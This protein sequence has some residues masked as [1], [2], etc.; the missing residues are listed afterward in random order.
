MK[1]K[2]L[3][4]ALA[5]A[6][7]IAL[8]ASCESSEERAEAHYEKAIE[9]IAAGDVDRALVELR[10]VFRLDGYHRE[11]RRAFAEAEL[12]RGQARSAYSQYL[13]L[14]EQYPDDFDAQLALA[15]IAVEERNWD[16]VDRHLPQALALDP[17]H[18]EV[19]LIK[20]AADYQ[21]AVEADAPEERARI[22]AEVE[23][24]KAELPSTTLPHR[25][26]ADSFARD[27]RHDEALREAKAA[28]ALEPNN[29]ELHQ[30][31]LSLTNQLGDIDAVEQ[32]L[33]EMVERFPEEQ[34]V[35]ATLVRW[36]LSRDELDKAEAYLRD[37]ARRSDEQ[38]PAVELIQFLVQFRGSEHAIAE[39]DQLLEAGQNP[40]LF[41]SIRAGLRFTAGEHEAAIAE[42]EGILATA[43]PS[44]QTRNIKVSL[45]RMLAQT[46]NEVG[47][48]SLVEEVLADDPTQVESLKMRANWLIDGDK[49]DEAIA[50]LRSALDQS[51]R[52]P[53]IMSLMAR[54]YDRAGSRELTG[55]MLS[56]AVEASNRAPEESLRYSQFLIQQDKSMAAESV[57]VESLRLQPNDVAL[58]RALG[59]LHVQ[60][61][62]WARATQ[63]AQTLR[64]LGDG[65]PALLASA[66]E[67]DIL[68]GQNRT[69]DVVA[70][71]QSMVDEGQAGTGAKLGIIKAHVES[72]NIA[73][74]ENY[75]REALETNPDDF[76]LVFA[77]GALE[78]LSG[79]LAAA[80]SAYRTIVAAQPGA[81]RAWQALLALSMRSGDGAAAEQVLSEAIEKNPGSMDLLWARATLLQQSGKIDEAIAIYEDLY[82]ANSDSQIVANN[83]ASL[84]ATHRG[85]AESIERAY[86][87]ARRLRDVP[88][89]A[90]QDTFGWLAYLR[91]DYDLAR[92]HLEPAAAALTNDP[93]VQYH[94]GMVELAQERT[95]AAAEQFRRA[96]ALEEATPLAPEI[97][98]AQEEL[99]RLSAAE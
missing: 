29:L 55:E 24:L 96:V 45:A 75:L 86:G 69:A 93:S 31:R 32:Q 23:R 19:R 14:V 26:A 42:M 16:E 6:G 49:T 41:R 56:L 7:G 88:V 9:L 50:A 34:V 83:L 66:L 77:G 65:E 62:D 17:E 57:L 28:L 10:N 82:A 70:L 79:D 64:R 33:L 61:E 76:G 73:A 20:A 87:I 46:G 58:L 71:L 54:A 5:A 94:L 1:T 97:S 59:A 35:Q 18:A 40:D 47:A 39:V 38:Q 11:A 81:V 13:R 51:P 30:L 36:Y 80:Q 99:Q 3:L 63:V 4:Q 15:R 74:A 72:G 98:K 84:L 43:E 85:D 44:E 37:R 8:L 92:E 22:R 78:E 95:D 48:R 60:Q 2:R 91:G 53:Q 67:A 90:F 12:R 25:I 27:G 89:P 21:N 68:A 52:D